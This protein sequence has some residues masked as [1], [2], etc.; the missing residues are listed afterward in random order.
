MCGQAQDL[1]TES[2]CLRI[3]SRTIAQCLFIRSP[4]ADDAAGPAV[5]KEDSVFLEGLPEGIGVWKEEGELLKGVICDLR[6]FGFAQ[7]RF[8]MCDVDSR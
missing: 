5:F 2:F 3:A 1:F 6:S 7:D 4:R 8:M